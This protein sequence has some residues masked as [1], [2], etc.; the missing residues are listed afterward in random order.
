MRGVVDALSPTNTS[1]R[2][3]V[4]TP[5]FTSFG[6]CKAKLLSQHLRCGASV[7]QG[8]KVTSDVGR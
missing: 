5:A 2:T 3:V 4:W 7:G 6:N 1:K 8:G